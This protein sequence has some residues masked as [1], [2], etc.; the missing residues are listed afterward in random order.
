M[1][2]PNILYVDDERQNLVSFKASFRREYEIF[3]AGSGDEALQTL[4][5]QPQI[6]VV[7]SDQRMPG[8]TGVQLFEKILSVNPDP[9][10]MVMTG[11]SDMEAI[12]QAINKGKIYYYISKP[13]KRDELKVI[14]ENALEA[15]R[16][17]TENRSL[18]QEKESLLVKAEQQKKA[19]ILSQFETLKNQVNP[20]FLFNSLN[21][22]SSL[23]HEDPD[24]AEQFISKLTRVYRYVLDLKEEDVVQL[25]EEINFVENYFFLQQIRFGNSLQ[26]YIQLSSDSSY[27]KIPPLTLQI[28]VENAIKHNIASREQPLRVELFSEGDDLLVVRNN[29]QKRQDGVESTGLGLANLRARYKFLSERQPEFYLQNDHYIAKVPLLDEN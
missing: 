20:H 2:K 7:I 23:V 10:R 21:A 27:K 4:K 29:Y 14:I 19:H 22:L 5:S 26:L 17:K 16:L 25:S 8:M 11:Y 9:V 12:V 28:L 13:W 3:I 18:H 6:A 15:Y 24:L 1:E